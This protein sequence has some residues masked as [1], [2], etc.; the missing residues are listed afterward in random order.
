MFLWARLAAAT[1]ALLSAW[2]AVAEV[3]LLHNGAV[4]EGAVERTADAVV[5][6]GDGSYVRL[7]AADVAMV[8]ESPVAAYEWK[9]GQM[10]KGG[11]TA[12]DHLELA[13]WALQSRLWPQ[14][15]RELL[16]ARQLTPGSPRLQLLERRLDEALRIAAVAE[17]PVQQPERPQ[18]ASIETDPGPAA[19][20]TLPEGAL[21]QFTRRIQ[22]VLLNGCATSGC[23]GADPVGGFALDV[24]PLRG[25]GDI[26]STQRNLQLTLQLINLT[27]PGESKLLTMARGPHA[28]VTPISGQRREDILQRLAA[29]ID[30]IAVYNAPPTPEAAP[31]AAPPVA[32][33]APST[34]FQS[35]S[36]PAE[37]MSPPENPA[38][39]GSA[40]V[41][42]EPDWEAIVAAANAKPAEVKRGVVLERVGPRDEFDPA[43][44][45]TRYRR[46][47]DD[48][49]AE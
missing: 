18:P 16:D 44:F 13:D 33:A 20:A 36:Q 22:P 24:A 11:L 37:T 43:V 21:E 15:A 2:P 42:A 39:E 31:G 27:Q 35:L 12:I 49:P 17:A 34:A 4:F 47:Q 46:P 14:A 25:Y 41:S 45:N 29:W 38:L 1:L 30:D 48:R 6:E 7:R 28:G 19:R 23:H 40:E 5:V 9:R 26:R 10:G 32:T 3:V 8:A